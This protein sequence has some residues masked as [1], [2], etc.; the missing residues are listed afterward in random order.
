LLGKGISAT[1]NL[2]RVIQIEAV[3]A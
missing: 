1:G 2:R 3:P